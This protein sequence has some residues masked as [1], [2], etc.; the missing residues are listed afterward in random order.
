MNEWMNEW[1]DDCYF[2]PRP[3]FFKFFLGLGL[4]VLMRYEMTLWIQ[5]SPD[6]GSIAY[7]A[8][9]MQTVM[10][11]A[12]VKRLLP[13]LHT[14]PSS[15]PPSNSTHLPIPHR[16][17]IHYLNNFYGVIL[18]ESRITAINVRITPLYQSFTSF[19]W[20][21]WICNFNKKMK[22]KHTK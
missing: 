7:D 21:T 14:T 8:G 9:D 6:A 20:H 1:L 19:L 10:Y 12:N 3:K 13:A 17:Y 22:A 11:E 16:C 4:L 15:K 2:R 18:H 5:H